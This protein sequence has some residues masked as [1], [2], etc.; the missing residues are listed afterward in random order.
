[1]KKLT[2]LIVL[3]LN[4]TVILCQAQNENLFGKSIISQKYCPVCWGGGKQGL[5]AY[6]DTHKL[7]QGRGCAGCKWEGKVYTG[8]TMKC[9]GCGGTG[10]FSDFSRVFKNSIEKDKSTMKLL[11]TDCEIKDSDG[12]LIQGKSS[13][14]YLTEKLRIYSENKTIIGTFTKNYNWERTGIPRYLYTGYIGENDGNFVGFALE[15][16]RSVM[17]NA[18]KTGIGLNILSENNQCF[19]VGLAILAEGNIVRKSYQKAAEQSQT[20]TAASNYNSENINLQ[21]KKNQIFKEIRNKKLNDFQKVVLEKNLYPINGLALSLEAQDSLSYRPSA[22]SWL[23]LSG[24]E[25]DGHMYIEAINEKKNVNQYNVTLN[26]KN[27]Y[28]SLDNT[29]SLNPTTGITLLSWIKLND[30]VTNQNII[31]KGYT[32]ISLPYVQYSLKMNDNQPF[33]TPQFNLSLNNK[34]VALNGSTELYKGKWYLIVCTY[35]KS[36]MKIS[37]NNVLDKNMISE[38]NNINY[39]STPLNIGRW[40]TGNSQ[41]FDGEIGMVQIYNRA[42]TTSEIDNIWNKTKSKYGY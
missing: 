2:F 21:N 13:R 6:K 40:H 7:C 19:Y 8:V 9:M 36:F 15:S 28:V 14:Y 18:S 12:N 25:N 33:N 27:D 38:T 17:T 34:L 10:K 39:Y 4:T 35:D 26:G 1:M 20:L 11:P 41:Y 22:A 37:I 16:G 30:L 3:F 5:G 31:S 29:P 24:N 23:D 32:S 42:L